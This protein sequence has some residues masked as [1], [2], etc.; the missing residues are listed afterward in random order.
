MKI[1]MQHYCVF[2]DIGMAHRRVSRLNTGRY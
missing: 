1:F 2:G